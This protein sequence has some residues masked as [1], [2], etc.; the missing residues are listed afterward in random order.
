MPDGVSK[1]LHLHARRITFP[2]P[3]GGVIDVSAPLPQH[4]RDSF[5]MFGFDASRYDT[6]TAE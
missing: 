4:M 1:R 5:A 6:D 3:R 2:H